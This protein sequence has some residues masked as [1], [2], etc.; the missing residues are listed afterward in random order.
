MDWNK[1][2][3][4]IWLDDWFHSLTHEQGF[5]F[6]N[7]LTCEEKNNLGIYE[8][9]KAS[10]EAQTK[11]SLK[12]CFETLK[13]FEE[14][15]KVAYVDGY[16]ILR[17]SHKHSHYNGNT[18][19]NCRKDVYALPVSVA[20]HP[21]A[22]SV[23]EFY[24]KDTDY[25]FPKPVINDTVIIPEPLPNDKVTI[26]SEPVPDA[27]SKDGIDI[28]NQ[29][30]AILE[31]AK[32]SKA[33]LIYNK[34][35]TLTAKQIDKLLGKYSKS[36]LRIMIR[37]F[38]EWKITTSKKVE[39]DNLTIQK[40]WVQEKALE[41]IEKHSGETHDVDTFDPT[42]ILY[43]KQTEK[44]DKERQEALE[45][46]EKVNAKKWYEFNSFAEFLK[47]NFQLPTA[48]SIADY[49]MPD[50]LRQLRSTKGL[51]MMSAQNKI[52]AEFDAIYQ[53]LKRLK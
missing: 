14:A 40:T 47:L 5:F 20:L 53:Q 31:L 21:F 25:R 17:N 46:I 19:K 11:K 41:Y 9:P 6:V 34:K 29:I 39:D 7:L 23:I 48:K 4:K 35:S 36:V 38:Y 2:Q 51:L 8:Y 43:E 24:M 52:P 28:K 32:D 22:K 37:L 45:T 12:W 1:I 3:S 26:K 44:N 50:E 42:K 10:M 27:Y 13:L 16:I 30:D 33:G 15:G 49:E 18:I